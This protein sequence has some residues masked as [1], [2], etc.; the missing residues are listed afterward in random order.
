MGKLQ[1]RRR[2]KAGGGGKE[3][4]FR[5]GLRFSQNRVYSPFLP[6]YGIFGYIMASAYDGN[7]FAGLMTWR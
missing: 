2:V 3:G 5:N 6:L 7:S 4:N 1:W